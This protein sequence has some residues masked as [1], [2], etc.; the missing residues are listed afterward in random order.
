MNIKSPHVRESGKFFSWGVRNHGNL[1][2]WNRKS[3]A[4]ESGIQF[5]KSRIPLTIKI[6]YP[7]STDKD[8]NPESTAWYPESKTVV[9]CWIPFF[10]MPPCVFTL[11]VSVMFLFS[12]H[13][14]KGGTEFRCLHV[15]F[16][17]PFSFRGIRE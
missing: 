14:S 15:C 16:I 13:S 11:S 12:L 5:K 9:D 8:L 10:N 3:W 2:L 17:S 7:S 4:L 6:Q 1:C